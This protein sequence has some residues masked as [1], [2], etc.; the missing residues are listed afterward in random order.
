MPGRAPRLGSAVWR[1]H[2]REHVPHVHVEAGAL[3]EEHAQERHRDRPEHQH[4]QHIDHRRDDNDTGHHYDHRG[5][6]DSHD[7]H[8]HFVMPAEPL[9]LS[10]QLLAF[11]VS[12]VWVATCDLASR[13]IERC[14]A[15]SARAPRT[16]VPPS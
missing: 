7:G 11:A 13:V 10:H 3:N 15:F 4:L 1:S 6:D 5:D 9:N 12:E 2:P 14:T 16:I 8:W